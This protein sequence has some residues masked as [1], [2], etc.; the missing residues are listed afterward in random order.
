MSSAPTSG[1][2]KDKKGQESDRLF[3]VT[4][5]FGEASSKESCRR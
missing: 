1:S 4:M 5:E 3:E 2:G